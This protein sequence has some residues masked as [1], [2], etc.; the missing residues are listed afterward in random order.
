MLLPYKWVECDGG[1]GGGD[2]GGGGG[3]GGID[4]GG[5]GGVDRGG[6]VELTPDDSCMRTIIFGN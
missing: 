6:G 2:R 1:G 4:R 3:S 5:G